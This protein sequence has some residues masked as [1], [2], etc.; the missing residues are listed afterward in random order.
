MYNNKYFCVKIHFLF[1]LV[2]SQNILVIHR[3]YLL[4]IFYNFLKLDKKF[5]KNVAG[6]TGS[7]KNNF[8]RYPLI[9]VFVHYRIIF[10]SC[11]FL[12][13]PVILSGHLFVY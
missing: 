10:V 2:F 1:V 5:R 13:F 4:Y 7:L 8:L 9:V 3:I 6:K 12:S 11:F